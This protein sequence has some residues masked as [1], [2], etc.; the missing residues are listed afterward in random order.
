[1]EQDSLWNEST[2]YLIVCKDWKH[3]EY[4]FNQ[5]CDLLDDN[6]NGYKVLKNR[7]CV[8][9]VA[10]TNS[11]RFISYEKVDECTQGFRGE[12]IYAPYFETWIEN[13]TRY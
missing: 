7:L 10:T 5:F 9:I 13:Y 1:M 2:D 4:L 11:F 8:V 3:A 6:R 12:V